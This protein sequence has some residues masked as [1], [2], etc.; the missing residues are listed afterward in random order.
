VSAGMTCLS[1]SPDGDG[2]QLRAAGAFPFTS[3]FALPDLIRSYL[4]G[5]L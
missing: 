4:H 5:T 1:F 3:M 2:A